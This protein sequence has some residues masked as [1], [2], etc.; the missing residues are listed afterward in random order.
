MA[1]ILIIDDEV[2]IRTLLRRILDEDGHQIREAA[3]GHIGLSL[4]RQ[5]P[6]DVVI[7]DILMPEQDGLE[8]TLALTQEFLDARVIAITGATGDRNYLNV[9]TLFGARRVIQKPFTPDEIRRA[10][11][12]TLAH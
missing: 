3:D 8:V 4:Y 11:R 1:S 9:A 2:S 5:A 12:Y 6:A 10:V 7:T